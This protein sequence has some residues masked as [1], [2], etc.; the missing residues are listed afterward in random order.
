MHHKYKYIQRILIR[1]KCLNVDLQI[2]ILSDPSPAGNI[3][4]YMNQNNIIL[5]PSSYMTI[6]WSYTNLKKNDHFFLEDTH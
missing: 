6:L 4:I 1:S 2:H 3:I 5:I